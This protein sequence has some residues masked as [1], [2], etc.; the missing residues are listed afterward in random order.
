[1]KKWRKKSLSYSIK[2]GVAFSVNSSLGKSYIAP[3]AVALNANNL[4]VGLLTSVPD[5]LATSSQLGTPKLMKKVSRKKIVTRSILFEALMWLPIALIAVFSQFKSVLLVAPLLVIIFYTIHS[6]LESFPSPAWS[7]WLGDLVPA[8]IKGRFFGR[9][10]ELM[11]LAGLVALLVAGILLDIFNG[12]NALLGFA[13]LFLAAMVARLFG[14]YFI[15][16]QHEPKFKE[17]EK[18][19]FTFSQFMRRAPTNNFG[20][21]T[22]YVTLMSLAVNIAA[23]FFAVYMLRDLKF[24]YITF[25]IITISS[26][27]STILT[28]P[29]W[30]KF[31][32][33]HGNLKTL[34]LCGFSIPLIPILWMLSSNPVYLFTVELF[35]GFVWAGFNLATNNYV[36]DCVTRQRMGICFAYLN[37]LSGIGVFIGATAGGFLATNLNI[38]FMPILL[39]IFFISGA[40]RILFSAIMLPKLREV[41]KVEPTKPLWYYMRGIVKRTP[42]H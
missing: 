22:I 17:E 34:K 18:Y 31:S 16:K 27:L 36:Y 8:K 5:L 33:K 14:L 4:E 41:R 25:T 1:M 24:S 42:H 35:S 10:N 15:S 6:V 9:R 23:P 38:N 12:I 2:E 19:Y 11:Q 39:L 20:R 40:L 30:G 13:V 32:D 26:A 28:M 37:V 3:C 7:S 29:L 21:F